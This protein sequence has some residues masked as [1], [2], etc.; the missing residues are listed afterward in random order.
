M[1]K[2]QIRNK[3]KSTNTTANP[4]ISKKLKTSLAIILSAIAFILYA[5]SMKHDYTLDDHKV[6]DQNTITTKGIA[7]IPEIFKTD[8]WYGTGNDELRGPVYRPAPMMIYA[9]I[10]EYFPN[11]PQAYHFI[12]VVFFSAT[13]LLLFLLL[14]KLFK[15]KTLLFPFVCSLLYAAHPIHTEVVNNIK[16]LDEILCFLFALISIWFLLRYSDSK[17]RMPL[18]FGGISFFLS[19]LSKETGISFLLIIPLTLY[20]FSDNFK[21]SIVPVS[22]LLV[23][24][25]GLWLI[26]RSAIFKDL[27]QNFITETS[28]LNNTLYAAPDFI[29]KY[30]TAFYILLRYVGLLLFPH[31]LSCDYNFAQIKIQSFSDPGA[32]LGAIVYLAMGIY[33][34]YYLKK[35][36]IISFGILFYLITLAPVSNIFFLGGSSMAERFMY[37][38]SFGF[39]L[40]L[41]H[42]LIRVTKSE[43]I[44]LRYADL[45][46][47][48]STYSTLFLVLIGI[49]ALY[50]IKTISR[51]KDWKDTLTIFS[52]DIHV[53][54]N[55]ATA[56]ELLGNALLLRG[57]VTTN[58][59]HQTDSFNLAKKYLKRALE[60]APGFYYASSNLGYIY[61]IEKKAD[62]AFLY[63][64]E[65]IK[66]GPDNI[67]LNN[68]LGSSMLM[69]GKYDDA[70]K[71]FSHI[72]SI[73]PK[74]EDAYFNLA[75]S[76][77]GK[78]D[79]NKGLASYLR[80]IEINP[81]N[82]KAYYLAAGIYNAQ[83]NRVK[84]KEFI[85]KA[86]AL[87]YKPN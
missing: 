4:T 12:N 55:S 18:I 40:I 57:A 51:N 33:S 27:Q 48:F 61:I 14:F 22:I 38:P 76:Y 16:S 30:A 71:Q 53:S 23:S 5:Q 84:A 73:N 24:L 17:A 1:K 34:V 74:Y 11:N 2:K 56:N 36:T 78:G 10:W 87:G 45:P 7:G 62:S 60:I 31:P 29:S 26:I 86:I 44:A 25:T 50:S 8:Y 59:T 68:Y 28:A 58:K 42:L 32:I 13:C 9:I 6:V 39:C 85:D 43:K 63:L 47:F 35:K 67:E 49:T 15:E 80:L 72:I 3:P 64:K 83:G 75:S 65:G 52:R 82:G 21:K 54:P 81:A 41:A 37:I 19:L 70:V 77:L 66:Y 69:L 46:R 20:F 79:A